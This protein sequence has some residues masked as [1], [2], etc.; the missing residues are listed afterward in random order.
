[1]QVVWKSMVL[2]LATLAS[3]AVGA[4]PGRAIEAHLSGAPTPT[5]Q[6]NATVWALAYAEGVVYAGGDFTSVRPPGAPPGTGEVPRSHIAAFDASTGDLLPFAPTTDGRV[7]ALA[8]DANDTSLYLGGDF[9]VVDGLRRSHVAAVDPRSGALR[10]WVA[11]TDG[12]VL[13]LATYS[14]TVY[15]GGTFTVVKG[16]AR[17]RLAAVS[18]TGALL[19]WDPGADAT[20]SALTV[21]P[22]GTRVIAGGAFDTL[23]GA[24][25]HAIGGIDPSSGAPTP[26]GSSA[27]VPGCSAVHVLLTDPTLVYAGADGSGV[28]C[29]DGTLAVRP[30]DGSLAW[31]DFCL[32]ATQ[33]LAVI[34]DVLYSGSHVHDCSE[35][36]GGMQEV[37]R[38][39]NRHLLA[40]YTSDGHIGGA[41]FPNTNALVD[42]PR[43]MATDGRS[44][45]LGGDFT[46]VQGTDQQGLA[47]F[48]PGP[49]TTMPS[50]PIK[51]TAISTSA[52]TVS[53]TWPASTDLDDEDL[54]YSLYRD[55]PQNLIATLHASSMPWTRPVLRY[56]DTG[57][58]PGTSHVYMVSAS[59]RTNTT[60]RSSASDPV[61]VTDTSP[62]ST[63]PG[64]VLADG[65]DLYWRLGEASGSIA[66]DSSGHG[67]SGLYGPGTSLGQP[68]A[69][70]DDP[71]RAV[72][73]DGVT[74]L[75]AASRAMTAPPAFTEELWFTTASIDG[76][77]LIGFGKSQTGSS[78]RYDRQVFMTSSG[79]L[80]FAV[81]AGGAVY[82]I[83]STWSYNDAT[84]HHVAAT[85]GA[86]GMTLYVD[87]VAVATGPNSA[88]APYSGYWR[89]GGDNLQRWALNSEILAPSPPSYYVSGTV[90]EVAVYPLALSAGSI[91]AHYATNELNH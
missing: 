66:Q 90:D 31:Q 38:P 72:G 62:P 5:W 35:V 88:G 11:G 44:L 41:W 40:E 71:D 46:T 79:Q 24:T 37:V 84:W 27:V 91:A 60:N 83:R 28:G 51:P 32:G 17:D 34:G 14:G 8:V 65:P 2:A 7:K 43:A 15:M 36:P 87:G 76:G 23:A 73:L 22:D 57:L 77:M 82:K 12:S 75:V 59:D 39:N 13:A 25:E 80:V 54:T 45:W 86:G 42:G 58:K 85:L 89:V 47:W 4:S 53:V 50:T 18:D 10:G 16:V 81:A 55:G 56:R 20:V 1:M 26:W 21:T 9:T 19:A 49:D 6:T 64:A 78:A 52:G 33:A 68:G 48:G 61:L 3:V 67:R 30:A 74:G 63:Y 69:I 70:G 29:F